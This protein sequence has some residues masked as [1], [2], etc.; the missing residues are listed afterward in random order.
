MIDCTHLMT[1]K[2]TILKKNSEPKSEQRFSTIFDLFYRVGDKFI[3]G[4]GIGDTK[5][6]ISTSK[7][8]MIPGMSQRSQLESPILTSVTQTYLA[9]II[10]QR[11]LIGASESLS[12][13]VLSRE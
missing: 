11:A 7:N 4:T 9:E 3:F 13:Q 10:G 5:D 1:Q 8:V 6:V 2:H 12:Q